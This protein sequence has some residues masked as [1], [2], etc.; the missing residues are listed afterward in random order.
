MSFY[1]YV[2]DCYSNSITL[3]EAIYFQISDVITTFYHMDKSRFWLA[4][5]IEDSSNCS[6]L[7][8]NYRLMRGC[9]DLCSLMCMQQFILVKISDDGIL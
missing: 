4:R 2:P 6:V 8:V 9:D 7:A 3:Q 5:Y 1:L